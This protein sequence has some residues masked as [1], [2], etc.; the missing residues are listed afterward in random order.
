MRRMGADMKDLTAIN[1]EVADKV[2]GEARG[3]APVRSGRLRRSIKPKATQTRAAVRAGGGSGKN[4]VLY[5]GPIHFGWFL[6][7]I[8]PQPF[9]YDAL[10]AR[11]D[12]IV[13][14]YERRVAQLVEK[15]D[16]ETPG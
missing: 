11:K 3:R 16:R 13:R 12:E 7:N 2:V 6:R 10:D 8:D 15:L 1:R 4:L 14:R 9:L 5:A